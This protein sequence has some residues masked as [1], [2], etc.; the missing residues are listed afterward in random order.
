MEALFADIPSAIANTVEIARRCNLTLAMGKNYLPD[1][2]TPLV[3]GSAMPM[4][5]YFRQ[6]ASTGPGGAPAAA[7]PRPAERDASG[8]GTSSASS[9]RS[10]RS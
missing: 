3:D 7:V 9:S 10:S 5:D 1:F 4:G 8:R 2:P 6:L